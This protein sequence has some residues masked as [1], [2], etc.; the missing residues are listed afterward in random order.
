MDRID[1]H[2][3]TCYSNIRG[4][5]STNRVDKLISRAKEIG[6]K[7]IAITDHECLSAHVD[8]KLIEKNIRET[9]PDFKVI[10]GNEIYLCK[11]RETLPQKFYHFILL[12][13]DK[14][15]Y[16][17][18]SEL[19][20]IA[21]LNMFS[22]KGMD[23]VITTY[24]DLE[25]IIQKYGEGHL[26]AQSAC[27]GGELSTLC[28]ELSIA[29]SEGRKS[30]EKDIHQKIVA[31]MEYMDKLFEDDFYVECAPSR[32]HDQLRANQ[33]LKD[34]AQ[35]FG[36]KMIVAC[37]AHYLTKADRYVHKAYL[38]S[39]NADREVDAFY[40]FTYLQ[41]EE[42][43][44]ENLEFESSFVDEM[45]CNSMEIYNKIQDYSLF[46]NQYVVE[47][48][49]KDYQK[50]NNLIK[51]KTK[52][53]ILSSLA[54]S[55]NLQERYWI[56][57][58]FEALK[59]KDLFND[60]YIARLEYEAD[61]MRA[62]GEKLGTCIFAYSNFLQHYIDLFWE[63]GSIVGPGR[64]SAAGGLNYYLLG[65]TQADPI[66]ENCPFW[67]HLNKERI[68]LPDVDLDLCPTKMPV[69]FEKIREERGPLGI[70]QIATFK[71]EKTKNVVLSSCRGY[72]SKEY[73]NG[74]DADQA[75]YISS[76]IEQERGFLFSLSDTIYGNE[77]K[78]RKPNKLFIKEVEQYPGLLDIMLGIENLV[79]GRSSHASGVIFLEKGHE[80]EDCALMRTSSGSIITSL[81]LHKQELRGS[82][83]YDF[84]VTDISDKI[85]TCLQLLQKYGKVE[86]DWTI[87]QIYNKYLAPSKLPV[88]DQKYWDA[89]AEG[90]IQSLF[91]LDSMVGRQAAKKIHPNTIQ[92]LSQ[93]NGIMRLMAAEKGA[94]TPLDKYVRFKNN[95]SLWYKEMDENG[96]SKEEQKILEPYF[97]PSFGIPISQ[98]DLMEILMDKNITNFSLKEANAARKVCSKKIQEK[99][100]A[101]H[102]QIVERAPNK[103]FGEYVYK[104][105]IRP[106]LSYSFSRLHSCVY[107]YIGFQTAYLAVHF[108]IVYWNTACAIVDSGALDGGAAKYDK[109]ASAIGKMKVNNIS[110]APPNINDSDYT[111]S[112]DEKN[113]CIYYGLKGLTGVGEDIVQAIMAARPFNSF[114]DFI[115]RVNPRKTVVITLIKC[116]A[117]DCFGEDRKALLY[118]YL[119]SKADQKKILNL[120][121]FSM[122]SKLNLFGED[123]RREERIFGFN[124]Y[125]KENNFILDNED[126]QFYLQYFDEQYLTHTDNGKAIIDP[127]V[128][129]KKCYQKI[130]DTARTYIKDNQERLLKDLNYIN[131]EEVLNKYAAGGISD[132]E[133]ESMGY[134]Y[135][136]HVL[137]SANLKKYGIDS[138]YNIPSYEVESSFVKGKS[139]ITLY[140]IRKIAGTCIAK[141]KNKSIVT[142]LTL[143]GV[144]NVKLNKE[145][146][147]MYDRQISEIKEDGKK[148]II[149]RSWFKR[150]SMVMLQGYRRD[151][152]FV[153]KKY[154][155]TPG[156]HVTKIKEV[157]PNGDLVI[158]TER[159][160]GGIREE[161]EE[162]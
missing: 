71:T 127:K 102:Q 7:G 15:G 99:I 130:M 45:F 43:I 79:C 82:T 128:W 33:I 159:Y 31:F 23:R 107:S 153:C 149:E 141:D 68:E 60:V 19:S 103:N 129:D 34:V 95:L 40:E 69:I 117:F 3:H 150:G 53:P 148:K 8:A 140:K 124:K 98:E 90:H 87:R 108:P 9:N 21:W 52:Y 24:S 10:L 55:D 139:T 44:K 126:E 151:D 138:F 63:C 67:R 29:R 42:Q 101:L 26:I 162:I 147:A 120:R 64:G 1:T 144:V 131:Y 48:D 11:D 113:N 145:L 143:E 121:N 94:E 161:D 74:I 77:E 18:L 27:L 66:K 86:K 134:Y 41:T 25:N 72:R 97:K 37:D 118:R 156:H 46:K 133:M 2:N 115:E 96:L 154:S 160:Q 75:L 49:V 51:D 100:E 6:L 5:D 13:K 104:Y 136:D 50:N 123:L 85:L 16:Q 58:C 38:N 12:A 78:N 73:P 35:A 116:G 81:D 92:Q 158:Q 137:Q 152:E 20:S 132:W 88:N 4:L 62:V 135:H 14:I 114:D 22:Y 36:R 17:A 83:K 84:L 57:A 28:L 76:L 80:F 91:Q 39:Q 157:R 30:D 61:I 65:I 122:L 105:G 54:V 146:F 119:L 111:F 112:P 142:L 125:L 70:V 109:I 59:D 93:T 32:S 110:V 56:N 89:I 47:T 155:R 106:Q